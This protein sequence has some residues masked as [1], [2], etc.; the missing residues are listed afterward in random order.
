MPVGGTDTV[1]VPFRF[2][3]L[4]VARCTCTVLPP[5][6]SLSVCCRRRSRAAQSSQAAQQH[7]ARAYADALKVRC[8][9]VTGKLVHLVRKHKVLQRQDVRLLVHAAPAVRSPAKH[10]A[11]H[12]AWQSFAQEASCPIPSDPQWRCKSRLP[13]PPLAAGGASAATRLAGRPL[14]QAA[15]AAQSDGRQQPRATPGN[16]ER[17]QA[18]ASNAPARSPGCS[19]RSL[20]QRAACTES[21]QQQSRRCPSSTL[22]ASQQRTPPRRAAHTMQLNL[23]IQPVLNAALLLVLLLLPA[24]ASPPRPQ[25]LPPLPTPTRRLPSPRPC[26]PSQPCP[27]GPK[28]RTATL[29][30][31]QQH[32][33]RAHTRTRPHALPYRPAAPSAD[34]TPA[35]SDPSCRSKQPQP[36][37]SAACSAPPLASPCR[38]LRPFRLATPQHEGPTDPDRA[39]T[40]GPPPNNT[41]NV[42]PHD[43][44]RLVAAPCESCGSG[45]VTVSGGG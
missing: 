25:R 4:I 8:A 15:T 36:S 16:S 43:T 38:L 19:G 39:A 13:G 26:L 41:E 31:R 30:P 10:A 34:P 21:D 32:T 12:V 35:L 9:W 28:S 11:A 18:A 23:V 45:P 22:T 29:P 40:S 27:A 20:G 24:T 44:L 17:R 6:S 14:R 1:L 2:L 37:R 33:A 5:F 7:A 3:L 42:V